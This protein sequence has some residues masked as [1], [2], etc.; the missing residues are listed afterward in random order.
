L[1]FSFFLLHIRSPVPLLSAPFLLLSYLENPSDTPE[2]AMFCRTGE[3]TTSLLQGPSPATS[4]VAYSSAPFGL[5]PPLIKRDN[6]E[7]N[8][9]RDLLNR[10]FSSSAFFFVAAHHF[11]A[12]IMKFNRSPSLP[13]TPPPGTVSIFNCK[14]SPV[15]PSYPFSRDRRRW[16]SIP[17]LTLSLLETVLH[18]R[19]IFWRLGFPP[20]C[21]NPF[22][23]RG[24]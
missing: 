11:C 15:L 9:T 18:L 22:L 21:R 19:S 2:I 10:F 3:H 1:I 17:G 5:D 14:T 8:Y 24:P 6:L 23:I 12:Q 4:A 7:I 13:T 16:A 20:Y